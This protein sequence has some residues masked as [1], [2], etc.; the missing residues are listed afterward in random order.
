MKPLPQGLGKG[1]ANICKPLVWS[2]LEQMC[3]FSKNHKDSP[4]KQSL[5]LTGVHPG[6]GPQHF[7]L[8]LA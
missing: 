7:P 6:P 4:W 5:I 1:P 3:L 8:P 2:S